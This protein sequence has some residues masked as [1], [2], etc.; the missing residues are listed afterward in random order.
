VFQYFGEQYELFVMGVA[1]LL[2]E[3]L[4]LYWLYRQKIHVR[5]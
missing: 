4:I 3:W 2:I 1:V 5:I